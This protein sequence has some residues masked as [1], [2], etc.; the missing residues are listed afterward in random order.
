MGTRNGLVDTKR[1]G[2]Q[3]SS[4]KSTFRSVSNARVSIE[5]EICH[6]FFF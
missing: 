2:L 3:K 6:D 5:H 1:F 4:R